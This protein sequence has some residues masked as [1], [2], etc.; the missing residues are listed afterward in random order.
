VKKLIAVLSGIAVAVATFLLVGRLH[1]VIPATKNWL[2]W[3]FYTEKY[4]LYYNIGVATCNVFPHVGF[5]QVL[6]VYAILIT[7]LITTVKAG[8]H[9]YRRHSYKVPTYRQLKP[10]VVGSVALILVSVALGAIP[11]V[12]EYLMR[13]EIDWPVELMGEKLIAPSANPVAWKQQNEADDRGMNIVRQDFVWWDT[14]H[15]TN[16]QGFVSTFNY[17]KEVI[18][19]VRKTGKKIIFIF[20]DSFVEGFTTGTWD[21]TFCEL[22]RKELSDKYLICN[23]GIGGTDPLDYRLRA[24]KFVKQLKPDQFILCFCGGNDIMEYNRLATPYIPLWYATSLHFF[25]SNIYNKIIFPTPDS[26]YNYFVSNLPRNKAQSQLARYL[27]GQSYIFSFSYCAIYP[28]LPKLDTL[29]DTC[30]ATYRHLKVIKGICTECSIP[31]KIVFEPDKF[32]LKNNE[33][34][35]RAEY[36]RVFKDLQPDVYFPT[37]YN[38]KNDFMPEEIH[39]ND[40]G[41]RKFA[42]TVKQLIKQIN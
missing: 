24:E 32:L 34:E 19:S 15:H 18:D 29:T 26:L 16:N 37:G 1:E 9:L 38:K 27:C 41:N 31:F 4:L 13:N 10:Y 7:G 3:F 11:G 2:Y 5:V 8:L 39:F 30:E 23:F 20:G 40:N 17:T 36:R 28:W 14:L 25:T 6:L 22:L 35:Y 21:K 42:N 12:F 33:E